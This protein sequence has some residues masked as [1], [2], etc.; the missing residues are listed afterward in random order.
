MK[1][2]YKLFLSHMYLMYYPK[3]LVIIL[4]TAQLLLLAYTHVSPIYKIFW[5]GFKDVF[6]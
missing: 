1:L 6:R 4:R 5:N 3:D 2:P